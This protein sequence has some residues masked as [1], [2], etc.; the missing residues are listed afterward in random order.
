MDIKLDDKREQGKEGCHRN[1]GSVCVCVSSF[2]F[3]NYLTL[4][5]LLALGF[6]QLVVHSRSLIPVRC[7]LGLTTSMGVEA[8]FDGEGLFRSSLTVKE[9]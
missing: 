2:D 5:S 1:L 7:A 9:A 3:T 8:R 6:S 4:R